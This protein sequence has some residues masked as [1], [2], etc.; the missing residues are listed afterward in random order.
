MENFIFCAVD[1]TL[2]NSVERDILHWL[3]TSLTFQVAK[4]FFIRFSQVI[5]I[6]FFALPN[7]ICN[8]FWTLSSYNLLRFMNKQKNLK[9]A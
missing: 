2:F 4:P 6:I 7:S 3:V 1:V 8:S 5:T 9:V